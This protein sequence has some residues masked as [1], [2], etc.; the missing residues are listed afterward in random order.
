MSY[1][2][3]I[4]TFANWLA[5]GERGISSEAIVSHLTG[6]PVGGRRWA[7]GDHPYDP[8]DFWRCERLLR[9]VPL[10]RLAFPLMASR[11]P[12]WSALVEAWDELVELGESE[13]PG[14]FDGPAHGRAPKMYARMREIR[15]SATRSAS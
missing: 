2:L 5:T 8:D 13:V 6:V 14:I 1:P 15:Q 12:V 10:A 4:E 7:G 11:S 3:K 9:A